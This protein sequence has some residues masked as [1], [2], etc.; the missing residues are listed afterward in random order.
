[1]K[2]VKKY[3]KAGEMYDTLVKVECGSQPKISQKKQL[4]GLDF[5]N[6]K[7][8]YVVI[9]GKANTYFKSDKAD[10]KKRS[11][12]ERN[13]YLPYYDISMLIWGAPYNTEPIVAPNSD[14]SG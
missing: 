6:K 2:S 14:F 1:M 12:F 4:E 3:N 13:M 11:L 9:R 8:H 7:K 5:K 10:K